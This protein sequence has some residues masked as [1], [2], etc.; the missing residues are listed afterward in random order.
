MRIFRAILAAFLA[1]ATFNLGAAI[2]A[3][4][5]TTIDKVLIISE[6]TDTLTLEVHYNYD[7]ARPAEVRGYMM[8]GKEVSPHHA[9]TPGAVRKGRNR[10]RVQLAANRQAPNSFSS[11]A[12]RVTLNA[13][14]RTKPLATAA[15]GFAKTW[16]KPRTALRPATTIVAAR[17][18]PQAAAV[19]SKS[20][21]RQTVTPPRTRL[22]LLTKA[23]RSGGIGTVGGFKTPG[24]TTVVYSQAQ[25]ATPPDSAPNLQHEL[26]ARG[27]ADRLLG[28]IGALL[29]DDAGA[30]QWY[31]STEDG[32]TSPYAQISKRTEAIGVMVAE[33]K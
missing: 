12:V 21:L 6:T 33:E 8:T 23:R 20:P 13:Q 9:Y 5:K 2:P 26:W 29:G 14:G 28:I 30:V 10:T 32:A 25:P 4:A 18:S 3:V 16:A 1:A 19:L 27:E 15:Y 22:E 11:D 7:G 24:G 31:K 17:I